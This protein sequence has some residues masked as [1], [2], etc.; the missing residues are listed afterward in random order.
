MIILQYMVQK[1]IK[2]CI[3]SL[4]TLEVFLFMQGNSNFLQY[5]LVSINLQMLHIHSSITDAI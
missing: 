2:K 3:I 5:F 1:N 4:I